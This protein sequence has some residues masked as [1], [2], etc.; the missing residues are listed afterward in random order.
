LG[1]EAIPIGITLMG[2]SFAAYSRF[3][4]PITPNSGLVRTVNH[5]KKLKLSKGDRFALKK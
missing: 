2:T 4:S 5:E 3:R 1:E